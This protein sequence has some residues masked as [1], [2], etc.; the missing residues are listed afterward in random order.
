MAFPDYAVVVREFIVGVRGSIPEDRWVLHMAV[1]G[2]RKGDQRRIMTQATQESVEG[3]WQVLKAWRAESG[4]EVDARVGS[5]ISRGQGSGLQG[6]PR[7]RSSVS[8]GRKSN[9]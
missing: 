3:S 4:P 8:S 9:R 1:L 2:V 5:G 7:P 6:K